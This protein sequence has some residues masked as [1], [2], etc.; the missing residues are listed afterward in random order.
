M[1]KKTFFYGWTVVGICTIAMTLGYGVRH[2]FSVFFPPILEEFGWSRGSTAV[3]LSIHLLFYGIVSP[4]SG[5]LSDH[6]KPKKT[7]ILGAVILGISTAACGLAGEL[8]HFYLIFGF[9]T[10]IGLACVGAPVVTPTI[11]NWFAKSRGLAYGIA[12]MGGGLSFIYAIYAESMISLLGWRY[13]YLVLGL[14]IMILLIPVILLFYAGDPSE[15]N[16]K[17]YGAEEEDET[18]STTDSKA[19]TEEWTLR[20]ALGTHQLWLMVASMTL[21]WGLG[22]YM[23][24]AHQVK[25]AQD[26]GYSSIFAASIFGLYG[27]SMVAGQ[28]SASISDKI[29]RE[30]VLVTGCM[31]SILSV[32]ALTQVQ[33]TSSSWLLYVY[34]LGFGYGSGLQAP[35]I[36]VGA[37]D[38]F[39]GKHFGAING[40]ILAGMGI[41]GSLGPWLGGFLHDLFGSY[42][43]AFGIA[44]LSF[45]LSALAFVIAA[46]RRRI[47]LKPA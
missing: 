41:G 9:I 39:A 31:L 8:W 32:F 23:V 40:M 36:F 25:F 17:P 24:L 35:M 45:A 1:A 2:S 13:A 15:K 22:C 26:I 10:P 28:L 34:S 47:V 29:G 4:F 37:S 30:W 5:A 21:F 16:L 20:K 18:D 19:Q 7:I 6:W 38:L 14:S 11:I 27:L 44:M 12:Q 42:Q 43:A 3:M 46:P 33:D